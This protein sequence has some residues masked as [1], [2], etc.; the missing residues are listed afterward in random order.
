MHRLPYNAWIEL[1]LVCSFLRLYFNLNISL[2]LIFP[3]SPHIHSSPLFF[4]LMV[5]LSSVVI[6]CIYLCYTHKILNINLWIYVM[7][8]VCMFSRLT[9]TEQP[10]DVLFLGEDHLLFFQLS[11]NA[12]VCHCVGFETLWIFPIHVVRFVGVTFGWS[13][14]WPFRFVGVT[15]V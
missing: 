1:T 14:W 2:F 10:I 7:I 11:S 4:K 12:C 3:S 8:F 9:G 6:A 5:I 15:F 13:C